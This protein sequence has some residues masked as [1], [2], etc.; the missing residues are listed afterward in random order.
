MKGDTINRRDV[1]K[2]MGAGMTVATT[3]GQIVTAEETDYGPIRLVEAAI[4]Y[5]LAEDH[6]YS[7]AHPNGDPLY[8]VN[9]DEIIITAPQ[10]KFEQVFKQHDRLVGTDRVHPIP[11]N[12]TG[13]GQTTGL[14]TELRRRRVPAKGVALAEPYTPPTV[15]I[16]DTPAGPVAIVEGQKADLTPGAKEKITLPTETV[17]ARTFEMVDESPSIDGIPDYR[18]GPTTEFGE[19]EVEV[20]PEVVL[21]DRGELPV[22]RVK[23]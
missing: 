19:V 11:V 14:V 6:N 2:S 13:T 5:Q 20:T 17:T 15:V 8:H 9:E 10:E 23:R 12:V 16:R 3:G 4:R 7:G 18:T 1:L 21:T 22:A